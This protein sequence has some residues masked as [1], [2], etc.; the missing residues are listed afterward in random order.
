MF[1][2]PFTSQDQSVISL[3]KFIPDRKTKKCLQWHD[4]HT[5][6]YEIQ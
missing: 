3:E 2:F 5:E 6:F 4:A 1:N